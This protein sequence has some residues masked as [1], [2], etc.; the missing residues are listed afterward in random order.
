ML[1]DRNSQRLGLLALTEAQL[2][3]IISNR[4]IGDFYNVE[5][6]VF[7]RGKFANVRKATHKLTG[8]SYAA[9]Y[10]KKR[11]GSTYLLPEIHHEIAVLRM[12]EA[13]DRIVRMHE[14]YETTTEVILVL[15][16][17]AGG[18]LQHIFDREECL[19]EPDARKVLKQILDGLSFLH[20]HHIAHLDLKP[21]NLLLS[22][23]AESFDDVKLCDFGVSKILEPG[24]QVQAIL[25]TTDYVSPEILR[26]DPITLKADIWSVGVLS[27]VL[28]TGFTPF[29][30]DDKQQTYLNIS[31]G[32]VT[33]EEELFQNISSSAIDFIRCT[34]VLDPTKRPSVKELLQHNWL[35][36]RLSMTRTILTQ[37]KTEPNNQQQIVARCN[38]TTVTASPTPAVPPQ[39]SDCCVVSKQPQPQSQ[40]QRK[41]FEPSPFGDGTPLRSFA[42]CMCAQCGTTCRHLPHNTVSKTTI[43]IDRG[44]LC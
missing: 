41:S 4:P 31:Q 30:A 6:T 13:N 25:G 3:E 27:Y 35:T 11:R 1:G 20:D 8:V 33:F 12:C 10:I 19:T 15:E 16:L 38:G 2:N 22:T 23:D 28:L 21:Q 17:A 43:T 7:A 36:P 34:L 32:D 29:S 39:S 40:Q 42:N 26:Y 14:V 5:H 24:S 44:I 18:E 37:I 9:K